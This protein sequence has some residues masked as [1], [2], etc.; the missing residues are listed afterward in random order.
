MSDTVLEAVARVEG[1]VDAVNDRV[2][3]IEA[4]VASF[5]FKKS[6]AVSASVSVLVAVLTKVFS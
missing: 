5:E 6:A 1:K 2:G 4:K 3:R